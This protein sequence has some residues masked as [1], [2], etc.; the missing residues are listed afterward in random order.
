MNKKPNDA[1][2]LYASESHPCPYLP[3]LQAVTAFV[4]PNLDMT[5][6]LYDMLLDLGFRRSGGQV[7]RPHCSSCHK[8]MSVRIPVAEYRANRNQRRTLAKHTN[9]TV[10]EQAPAFN[11]KHL[12]LYN[13]Y[14]S[15]RHND[16]DM[17]N[18]SPESYLGFLASDWCNTRFFE[19]HREQRLFAV[20]VADVLPTGLSAVYTF[21][22]PEFET[23]SPGQYAILWLCEHTQR[24]S[25]PWLYLGY[26]V[27]DCA[28]LGL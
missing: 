8:C 10:I 21:F 23:Y 22:D 19:F 28:K 4:D 16:S 27:G 9:T 14:L 17:G 13:K 12:D 25:K 1:L 11:Q 15:N 20:A 5:T 26:W 6:E 2:L 7:Y 3:D 18:A 24:L